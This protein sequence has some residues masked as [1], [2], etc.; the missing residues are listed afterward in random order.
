MFG[1]CLHAKRIL[2]L[3]SAMLGVIQFAS[4]AIALIAQGL[5]S[6]RG[7]NTRYAIK[8]VDRLLSNEGIDVDALLTRHRW[9]T[10]WH[11]LRRERTNS[12]V[13]LTRSR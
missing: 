10:P 13:V 6:V 7:L 5:V 12:G 8:Q 2:S 1:D 9:A 11:R 3:V 4:L